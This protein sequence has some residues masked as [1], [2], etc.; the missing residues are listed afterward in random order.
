VN[1]QFV[2][3]VPSADLVIVRLAN[4]QAGSEHWDE[5]ARGFLG[6]MLDAIK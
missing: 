3:V 1:G 5:F 2:F 6:A 4:D